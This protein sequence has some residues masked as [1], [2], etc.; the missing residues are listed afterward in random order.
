MGAIYRDK[1]TRCKITLATQLGIVRLSRSEFGRTNE[2]ANKARAGSGDV[3]TNEL[4]A[5]GLRRRKKLFGEAE[6][7]KR[8]AA[9]GEFGAPLQNII[10]AY[11]YRDIWDPAYQ[12]TSPVV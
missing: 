1:Q 7:E 12:T 4:Y 8:M 9:A 3:D 6:V 5:R 10:N 2:M 11:V